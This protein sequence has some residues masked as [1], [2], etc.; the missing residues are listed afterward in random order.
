[1]YKEYFVDFMYYFDIC[2]CKSFR[3]VD[4]LTLFHHIQWYSLP[5]LR[6]VE[7]GF[8]PKV[9]KKK[10]D[11][12]CLLFKELKLLKCIYFKVEHHIFPTTAISNWLQDFTYLLQ[13]SNAKH[14]IQILL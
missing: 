10:S 6:V 3:D 1:M 14:W 13:P 4:S 9:K 7:P 11:E 5:F 12:K 8:L 2:N